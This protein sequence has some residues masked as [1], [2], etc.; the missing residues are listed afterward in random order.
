MHVLEAPS[1]PSISIKY[2]QKRELA[3]QYITS[4]LTVDTLISTACQI[5][6]F[7]TAASQREPDGT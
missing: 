6:F 4:C 7:K 3:P 2:T 5:R 1:H